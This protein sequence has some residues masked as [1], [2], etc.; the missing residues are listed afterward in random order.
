VLLR[1]DTPISKTELTDLLEQDEATVSTST[2]A[3][4]SESTYLC[5][6]ATDL[7]FRSDAPISSS[8]IEF[9]HALD[10]EITEAETPA[11][12]LSESIDSEARLATFE[13]LNLEDEFNQ[14]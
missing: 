11:T 5:S 9:I 7:P 4:P 13:A 8:E 10:E 1:C 3:T 6:E 14:R 12:K 2:L